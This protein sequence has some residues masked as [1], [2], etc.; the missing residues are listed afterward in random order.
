[1][2]AI[3]TLI[4]YSPCFV[5]FSWGL[6]LFFNR[7]ENTRPQNMWM[8]TMLVLSICA[9][10]WVMLFG[11]I[12]DY[13]LYYKLDIVDITFTLLL[14][15]LFYLYFRTLTHKDKLTWKQYIWLLPSVVLGS[16]SAVLYLLLGEEQSADY[17]RNVIETQENYQFEA[18]TLQW[19]LYFVSVE[20]LYIIFYAQIV[21]VVIYSTMNVIRYKKGLRNFF[22][23]LEGKSLENNQAV[24]I[25][26]FGVLLIGLTAASVWRISHESYYYLKYV[27]MA[28]TSVCIY[29]MSYFVYKTRFTAENI[30]PQ[31]PEQPEEEIDT[32]DHSNDNYA[33]KLLPLLNKLINEDKIFL[34]PDLSL[35]HIAAQLNSNRT[36]IS[37]IINEEFQC[38][39]YDLINYKRIEYAKV[40]IVKNPN[41]IQ[42]QIARMSGFTHASSFSRVFKKLTGMTF[43]Q[44]QKNA[45]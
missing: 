25:G 11:G 29:Y 18:G 22:S 30:L 40:L 3:Y 33:T 45:N 42:E 1:M 14:F 44:W 24:L 15:P 34:Q 13:K 35:D 27:F 31:E 26:L 39:F 19:M 38:S 17:I 41:Y 5:S 4:L 7:K 12:D 23:N 21:A 32:V 8:I 9:F 43:R 2:T 16:I 6:L 36:Y 37:R 20:I 28:G 10:I